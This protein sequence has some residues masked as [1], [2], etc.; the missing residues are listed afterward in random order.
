VRVPRVEHL[1]RD[2]QGIPVVVAALHDHLRTQLPQLVDQWRINPDRDLS[3]RDEAGRVLREAYDDLLDPLEVALLG[4]RRDGAQKLDPEA[5]CWWWS[6]SGELAGTY[7]LWLCQDPDV[8]GLQRWLIVN[9]GL[10][11]ADSFWTGRHGQG[12]RRFGVKP[13]NPALVWP[14]PAGQQWL[15]TVT[16]GSFM[17]PTTARRP[18]ASYRW[19]GGD[20]KALADRV[21]ADL[22]ALLGRR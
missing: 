21:G 18:G 9:A 5:R 19:T 6:D 16:T 2:D 17:I 15:V 13:G 4:L 11:V 3:W 12:L 7:A 20:G 22:H 14:R 10:A 1:R 8:E